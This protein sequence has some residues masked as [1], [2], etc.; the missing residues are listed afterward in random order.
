MPLTPFVRRDA[1]ACISDRRGQPWRIIVYLRVKPNQF[2][3]ITDQRRWA[4][5][6]TL[7]L[8]DSRVDRDAKE[9]FGTHWIVA[10]HHIRAQVADDRLPVRLL[11]HMLRAYEGGPM[12]LFRGENRQRLADGR[13]GMA[14]TPNIETARMFG[15]GLNAIWSGGVLL[16]AHVEPDAIISG[17]NGHSSYLGEEQFTVDPFAVRSLSKIE[18]FPPAS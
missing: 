6:A 17:P 18:V 5:R 1:A 9:Q 10:G 11:R 14:W 7:L 8:A 13:L 16:R 4:E 12:E 2:E 15:R 3:E